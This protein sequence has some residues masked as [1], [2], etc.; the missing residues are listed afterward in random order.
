MNVRDALLKV[1]R[2]LPATIAVTSDAIDTGKVTDQGRQLAMVEFLV[3][4]PALT[5]DQLPDDDALEYDVIMSD[6]ADLSAAV[7]LY[8]AVIIQTGDGA[9]GAAGATHRFRLPTTAKRYIG[10]QI[11][12]LPAGTGAPADASAAAATLE[13]L[14]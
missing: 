12:P 14:V 10:I 7:T 6:S 1:T 11:N 3:T 2:A 9:A 5:T 8:P 13:A 4:A